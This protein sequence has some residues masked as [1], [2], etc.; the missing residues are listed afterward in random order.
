MKGS[1][2]DFE[3][4]YKKG[5]NSSQ[6][7]V[8]LVQQRDFKLFIVIFGVNQHVYV[9]SI[10]CQSVYFFDRLQVCYEIIR[11][12]AILIDFN[13]YD[14]IIKTN[15]NQRSFLSRNALLQLKFIIANVDIKIFCA[16]SK[17]SAWNIGVA[18][19]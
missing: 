18:F 13:R 14:I 4:L 1:C 16:K 5:R 12:R 7:F 11:T 17:L 8:S 6:T 9:K 15:T 2:F 3:R 10:F 19:F